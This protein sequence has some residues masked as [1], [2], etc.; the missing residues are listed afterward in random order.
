MNSTWD[1]QLLTRWEDIAAPRFTEK[2]LAIMEASPDA[3]VF[4]HPVLVNVWLE[5]YRPLRDI[6][7]LFVLARCGEQQAIFPLILWTRNWKNAWLR[8]VVPAGHSDFDYHDPI[9]LHPPTQ[10]QIRSF[11]EALKQVLDNSVNYDQILFDGIHQAY[12]PDFAQVVHQEACLSWPLDSAELQKGLLLP[13]KKKLASET[14]RRYRRLL[15]LGDIK[16]RRFSYY[17]LE[18][19]NAS[20]TRMLVEH[21]K[22]WPDAYKAPGF[23]HRLLNDGISAGLLDFI[24]LSLEEKPVAWRICFTYKGRYSLY[25]PAIDDEFVKYSPGHLSLSLGLAK[26]RECGAHTVDHLRGAEEYKNAWGGEITPIF[27]AVVNGKGLPSRLKLLF[28]DALQ[29]LKKLPHLVGEN[30]KQQKDQA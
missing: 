19:A 26:A 9:F 2:W 28:F 8:V 18:A 15:E 23:Q 24:E 21:S 25:M 30:S 3:H 29:R 6:Q 4:F 22:R 14:I 10:G 20:L 7:P 17:E 12:V 13:K 16:F 27:D 5:T 11:F 1:L